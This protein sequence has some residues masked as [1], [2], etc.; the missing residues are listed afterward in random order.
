MGR[1]EESASIVALVPFIAEKGRRVWVAGAG[2]WIC[3][4]ADLIAISRVHTEYPFPFIF[5]VL[6]VILGCW[7]TVLK[8]SYPI[9]KFAHVFPHPASADL[10]PC[11]FVLV[12]VA[13]CC[14][15]SSACYCLVEV[16]A[17]PGPEPAFAALTAICCS[18]CRYLVLGSDLQRGNSRRKIALKKPREFTTL[19]IWEKV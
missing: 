2:R 18:C 15:C 16:G 10:N 6:F 13:S 1:A 17:V 3:R 4:C 9:K 19:L 14:C 11:P 8:S 7:K 12:V 5:G